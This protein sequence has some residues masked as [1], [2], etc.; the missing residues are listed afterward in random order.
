[1]MFRPIAIFAFVCL[2]AFVV[3]AKAGGAG[4]PLPERNPLR[5]HGAAARAPVLP[6]DQP[7]VPWTDQEIADARAECTKALSGLAIEYEPLQPIK[8]GICGAPA[9]IL[10]RSIGSDPKIEIDPPA[11]VTCPLAAALSKWLSKTVQ[12]EAKRALSTQ[13]IKLRN[14]TSYS[15]RNR[16]G[17]ANTPLSE[18]AL[19]NALD[20]SEFVFASGEHITVLENWPRLV[21]TPP[22]PPPNPSRVSVAS[23]AVKPVSQVRPSAAPVRQVAK[24]RLAEAK[25][26]PFVAPT[27]VTDARTNPFVLPT[28]VE[29]TRSSPAPDT[30]PPKPAAPETQPAHDARSEFVRMVHDD[31]CHTFGTVLGPEANEAHKNH[32]H[33]DMKARRHAAVCE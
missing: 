31:A 12:P 27:T 2:V 20:V 13:L 6:G 9:P 24:I 1:M 4:V 3:Y 8:H 22:P 25:I 18:H 10:V 14:A 16:Y 17:G 29:E 19:A 11:T 30:I 5:P 15:C 7:T 28:A 21:A 23:A 26:Y 33:L 32:F